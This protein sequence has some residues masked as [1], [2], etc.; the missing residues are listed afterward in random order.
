M[1][2]ITKNLS[3][4]AL[5]LAL[6]SIFSN[7]FSDV[8]AQPLNLG[9]MAGAGSQEKALSPMPR[10]TSHVDPIYGVGMSYPFDWVKWGMDQNYTYGTQILAVAPPNT[11]RASAVAND[12]GYLGFATEVSLSLSDLFEEGQSL[13]EYLS[14][15]IDYHNQTRQDNK[16]LVSNTSA[17]LGGKPA[18]ALVEENKEGWE[19]KNLSVGTITDDGKILEIEYVAMPQDYNRYLP[20]VNQ[21]ISSFKFT[22]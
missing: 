18:Y 22:R 11:A 4:Y 2:E 10:F 8:V 20:I 13:N 7:V 3:F 1:L 19:T 15:L 9:Y 16:V 12:S 14:D 6:V 5:L 17:T 21:I